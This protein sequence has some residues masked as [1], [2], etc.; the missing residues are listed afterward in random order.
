[1]L[2]ANVVVFLLV[3]RGSEL[4]FNL[5]LFPPLMLARPWTPFTYM[6]L[7]GGFMHLLFNMIA[8]FFFGPRLESMLGSRHFLGLYMLSGVMGAVASLIPPYAPIVGAS[9]AVFGV[10]LGYAMFW[11]RDQILI[12]GI[13][14][15]EARIFVVFLTLL[16]LVSGFGGAGGG[17]A[18]FAHLGGFLG[19][20][21]YLKGR[22]RTSAARRF[23]K[24]AES[25]GVKMGD[26]Q[27]LEQWKRIR[28]EELHEVNREEYE[29]ISEKISTQGPS[30]LTDRERTFVDRFSRGPAAAPG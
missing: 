11:P 10:L 17:I 12:W 28:P 27:I 15:V 2:L 19:G 6:F 22:E 4:F 21:L 24:K 16:S 9:G 26:S 25:P 5:W 20:W 3:P 29:R 23:Q 13:V 18:H 8:L 1:L 7:H 30:S 14:P